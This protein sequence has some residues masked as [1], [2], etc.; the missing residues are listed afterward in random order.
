M[1]GAKRLATPMLLLLTILMTFCPELCGGQGGYQ[2]T[3]ASPC[4]DLFRYR[5]DGNE[6]H[7]MLEIPFASLGQ[8]I[9]LN[10]MLSLKAQLPT[11]GG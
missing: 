5:Y 3:P 10:V 7:G 1:N 4:P 2:Q 6:W 9:K 11:V 8:T